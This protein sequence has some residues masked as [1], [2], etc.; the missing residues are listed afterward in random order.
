MK[1]KIITEKPK[2]LGDVHTHTGY[3]NTIKKININ[4]KIAKYL[5]LL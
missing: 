5:Y 4:K 2:Y 1:N 3:L